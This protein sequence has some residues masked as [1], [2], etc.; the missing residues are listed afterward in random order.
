MNY[1]CVWILYI[2]AE[3]EAE[4]EYDESS[5]KGPSRWGDLKPDWAACK[6]GTMQSP[7]DL[8]NKTAENVPDSEDIITYYKPSNATL[9]NRGHDI[10]VS[11]TF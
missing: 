5:D 11:T 6:N 1:L 4:F 7:I 3:D 8:S 9:K 10:S 2:Y